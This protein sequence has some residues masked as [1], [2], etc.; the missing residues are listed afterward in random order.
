MGTAIK[1]YG[2]FFGSMLL[3]GCVVGGALLLRRWMRIP[4]A[5]HRV[6]ILDVPVDPLTMKNALAQIDEF[7][8]SG[9]PH[10]VFTADAT[11]IMQARHDPK[12]REIVQQADLITAD[13]AGVMFASRMHGEALPERVS[14][15][16][17]VE[18]IC[19]LAA[20]KGYTVFFFGAS[21]GVAHAAAAVLA[22]RHPG[23]KIAGTRH[24]FF[25]PADEP[26]IVREIADAK[27]DVLFVALGIP[28][29]ESFIH[30]HFEQLGVPVM[31]GIGGS[32]DVISGKLQRAPRWMQRT[33]I[34]WLYRLAQEPKRLP[35]LA[36]LPKFILANWLNH[37]F[38]RRG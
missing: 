20:K 8:R 30:D 36:A 32:F 7:V 16:D 31:I 19:A 13:G 10:H 18:R 37:R 17:L 12:L 1:K 29:Q 6:N 33:G 11:G 3:S 23:L 27:P 35:R 9:R 2:C 22:V 5:T 14:G 28:K 15:V 25:S 24:G 38:G 21:E 34:E 26:N 4:I